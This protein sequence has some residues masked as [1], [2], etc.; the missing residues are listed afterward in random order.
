MRDQ[1]ERAERRGPHFL[2]GLHQHVDVGGHS[3]S[4]ICAPGGGLQVAEVEERVSAR[5]LEHVEDDEGQRRALVG[6]LHDVLARFE[7]EGLVQVLEAADPVAAHEHQ[8]PEADDRRFAARIHSAAC[9]SK[10]AS[11][12]ARAMNQTRFAKNSSG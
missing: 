4:P 12:R 9:F 11:A 2:G 10:S 3:R 6:G 1:L 5:I 8:L 7:E